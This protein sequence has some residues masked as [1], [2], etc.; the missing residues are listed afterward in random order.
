M[1]MLCLRFT[2]TTEPDSW[3]QRSTGQSLS[4]MS[5]DHWSP[6]DSNPSHSSPFLIQEKSH[7]IL[8]EMVLWDNSPSP[9]QFAGFPN[10]VSFL[11]PTSR[12]STYWAVT[13]QAERAC[14]PTTPQLTTA[15]QPRVE[16]QGSSEFGTLDKLKG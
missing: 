10:K 6:F 16:S 11:A 1:T 13:W 15:I 8:G 3:R 14:S 7:F 5:T 4:Q 9:P 2:E 12:L